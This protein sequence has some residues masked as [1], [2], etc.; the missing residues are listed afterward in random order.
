MLKGLVFAIPPSL[1]LW[2]ALA[3]LLGPVR[4]G[5]AA[6]LI[7]GS[8]LVFGALYQGEKAK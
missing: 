7:G 8:L 2:A 5:A 4:V 3:Y 6:C 1:A